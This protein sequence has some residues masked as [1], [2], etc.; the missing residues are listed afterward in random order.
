MVG[1]NQQYPFKLQLF[2]RAMDDAGNAKG[3]K[4]EVERHIDIKAFTKGKP[5]RHNT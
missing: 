2:A 4:G 5:F 3:E 1:G